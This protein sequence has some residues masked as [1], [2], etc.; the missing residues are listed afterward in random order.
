MYILL[1]KFEIINP[2]NQR[3]NIF[4]DDEAKIRYKKPKQ[5]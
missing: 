5:Y 1:V 4:I 2:S 3:S